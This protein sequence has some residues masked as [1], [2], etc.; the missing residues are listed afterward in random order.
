MIKVI[1]SDLDGTLL[2]KDKHF[3]EPETL[4]I[5]KSLQEKGIQFVA[6][7][8]RQYPNMYRMFQDV[9]E[10]MYFI[11]EN[12][13]LIMY[14]GKVCYKKCIESSLGMELIKDIREIE[15]AEV[16]ISGERTSYIIPKTKAY[17]DMLIETV[18]NDITII[19]DEGLIREEFIKISLFMGGNSKVPQ[20]IDD[21]FRKKYGSELQIACSG[22]G[23]LDFGPLDAGK[24]NALEYL[25]KQ[26]GVSKQNTM[27]FGDNEND[28]SM[29]TLSPNSY[30]MSHAADNVKRFASRECRYVEDILSVL[31]NSKN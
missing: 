24:G 25:I 3:L 14:R 15:A 8:G 6:A 20:P 10:N 1:A 16:L 29:L 2:R 28:I 7:S 22:N 18:K 26:L 4:E 12:G 13:G 30:V 19:E 31:L 27:V 11:C 23:W 5:I 17:Q 9:A 21:C